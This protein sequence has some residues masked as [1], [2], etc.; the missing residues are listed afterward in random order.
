MGKTLIQPGRN[1]RNISSWII[2][3]PAD[4]QRSLKHSRIHPFASIRFGP[5]SS[6]FERFRTPKLSKLTK[7][8]LNWV[9]LVFVFYDGYLINHFS[10]FFE[11]FPSRDFQVFVLEFKG[12]RK[13]IQMA[14]VKMTSPGAEIYQGAKKVLSP[15][16]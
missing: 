14:N 7:T 1:F 13:F 6:D 12:T 8:S 10:K 11:N 4:C 9:N 15:C 2:E 3:S 5:V 16:G